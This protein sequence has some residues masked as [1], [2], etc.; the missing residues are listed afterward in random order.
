MSEG[1]EPARPAAG[2]AEPGTFLGRLLRGW[3]LDSNPLRRHLDRIETVL[4]LVVITGFAVAAPLAFRAAATSVYR[5]TQREVASQNATLRQVPAVLMEEPFGTVTYGY[6]S[7]SLPEAQARWT[8]PA[9]R[10]MT[11]VVSAP[12]G[13]HKGSTTLIWVD[14]SG[15]AADGPV[16]P[17]EAANRAAMAGIASIAVLVLLALGAGKLGRY[18]LDRRRLAAWDAD[19]RA[20][21][22]LWTFRR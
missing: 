8:S 22:P 6:A 21:G 3:S 5:I 18:A 19:W 13:L 16:P 14:R 17:S 10:Q 11:G 20:T 4:V 9:G 12:G 1:Q 7:V 2:R 15:Q